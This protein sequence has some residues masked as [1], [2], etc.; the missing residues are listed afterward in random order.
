MLDAP[1]AQGVTGFLKQQGGLFKIRDIEIQSD[2]AYA[3]VLA[4]AMDDLPISSSKRVLVQVGT[5]E[6]PA[7]W[8][9]RAVEFKGRPAEEVVDYGHAPWM[10]LRSHVSLSIKNP[11]L[12]KA[13]VLDPNGMPLT[14]IA[15]EN[16]GSERTFSFPA[17]AL[18][19]ILE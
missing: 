16:S 17:D 5:T 19:A 8:K 14:V 11:N 6:R 10:I 18:Y 2:D 9:T 13:R 3:T 15:L 1:K 7:G 4:V 12:S